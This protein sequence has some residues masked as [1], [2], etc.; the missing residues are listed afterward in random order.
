ME[1]KKVYRL[2]GGR[3]N[4]E[5]TRQLRL[6][7]WL[8]RLGI[9]LLR[10]VLMLLVGWCDTFSASRKKTNNNF[11]NKLYVLRGRP[12]ASTFQIGGYHSYQHCKQLKSIIFLYER[13]VFNEKFL[14]LIL[15]YFK[16]FF[17]TGI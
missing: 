6:F 14:S 5:T 10:C 17:V 15:T 2:R 8:F 11:F 4:Q 1:S 7:A 12:E 3:S 16:S 9:K 13:I